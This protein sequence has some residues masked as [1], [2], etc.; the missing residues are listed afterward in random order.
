LRF[1][2]QVLLIRDGGTMA[3]GPVRDLIDGPH[4]RRLYGAEIEELADG[5]SGRRA[6]LPG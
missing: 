2:D 5:P 6:Y 3:Q 1:A 4:L